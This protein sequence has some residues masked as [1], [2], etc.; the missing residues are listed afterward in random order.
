MANL[1][2][3]MVWRGDFGFDLAPW[4]DVDALMM[5]NLCYLNFHGLDDERGWSVAE[6]KRLDLVRETVVANFE[7]RKAQFE[8]MADTHRFGG[9]RMHHFIT[10]TDEARELQFSATCYDMPDGTLCIG[11]RGT[12]GTLVGWREDFNMSYQSTVPAQEAAVFYLQKAAELD[13]RPIRLVGHSKGGNLAAY[14]AA[15]CGEAVQ[16]R[17]LAVYSFDG[18]GMDPEIFQSEGY[19]RVAEKI[20]SF[21]PQTSIV[22]MMMEYHRH[23]TVVKS[24]ATGINQH[25]P[26][27]WQ[28]YGP[29]FE[30][31]EKID[32]N[33]EIISDTLHEWLAKTDRA[34]RAEMVDTLFGLLE[35]TK[36]ATVKE[37]MGERLRSIT[38]VAAG[39]RELDPESRKA[40]TKLVGLFLSLGF[41]N[42]AE[43]YRPR[44]LARKAEEKL[45]PE[46]SA[47]AGSDSNT[48]QETEST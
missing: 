30:T 37:M 41:G 13:D 1:M 39:T 24:S 14:A 26:L 7:G 36:A 46:S 29:R 15:C 8:A 19:Q 12:D 10:M 9:I 43:H 18:P 31:L 34:E 17:L 11:F 40:V 35:T 48:S 32:T 23:Y 28:V 25:D 27:T 5:S 2:D 4:N 33:A 16:D 45:V 20:R 3:Y 47:P 44:Q 42:L 38:S 22:G 6:A 21:V